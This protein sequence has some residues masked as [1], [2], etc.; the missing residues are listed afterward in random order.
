MEKRTCLPLLAI[1]FALSLTLLAP[2]RAPAAPSAAKDFKKANKLYTSG[3]YQDALQLYQQV[4]A[5]LPEDMPAADVHT[6]I[7][8]SYFQLG[9]FK[10]ALASYRNALR[11][12]TR[13]ERPMTQYWIGFCC[14]LSGRDD[15]AV[16]ELLKIPELYPDTGML[17]ATA[18]YWAGRASERM[19]KKEQAAGF[20][21]K[22]GGNGKSTQGRHAMKRANAVKGSK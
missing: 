6:R 14:F 5:A 4:L 19:G 9:D 17:V 2:S 13:P 1:S 12:Q 21:K 7:A 11:E 15:E 20:Y 18:Y 10:N 8:D 3:N 16:R 22:A